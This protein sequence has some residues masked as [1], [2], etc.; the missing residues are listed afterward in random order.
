ML[1][2]SMNQSEVKKIKKL[3]E[4]QK[5]AEILSEQIILNSEIPISSFV[6]KF[7]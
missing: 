3:T 2:F 5:M 6:V 7:E 4:L 1:E